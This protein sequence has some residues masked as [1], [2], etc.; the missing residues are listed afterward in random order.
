MF[1]CMRGLSGTLQSA[2]RAE[3]TAEVGVL[4][5]TSTL[6]YTAREYGTPR[7]LFWPQGGLM[8]MVSA[9]PF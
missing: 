3:C 7:R 4:A 9:N 2:G 5:P 6:I 8:K 1:C